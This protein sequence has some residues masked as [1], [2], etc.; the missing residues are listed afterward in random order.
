LSRCCSLERLVL[1]TPLKPEHVLV[2]PRAQAFLARSET[3]RQGAHA[4]Q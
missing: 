2:D 4:I 1:P 3:Q